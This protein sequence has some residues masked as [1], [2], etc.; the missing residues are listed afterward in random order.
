[1]S[2]HYLIRLVDEQGSVLAE[3]QDV[4]GVVDDLLVPHGEAH[5]GLA[6]HIDPYGK[7]SFNGAQCE[8]LL[9]E[10]DDSMRVMDQSHEDFLVQLRVLLR[11]AVDEV[12]MHLVFLGD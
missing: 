12:H 9:E 7:T 11:R 6:R 2:A 8:A 1:M 4:N 10:I 5:R 3:I